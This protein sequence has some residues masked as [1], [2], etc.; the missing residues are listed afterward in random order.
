MRRSFDTLAELREAMDAW[1]QERAGW[2][3]FHLKGRRSD[4]QLHHQLDMLLP[5]VQRSSRRVWRERDG[6]TVTMTLHYRDGVRLADACRTGC[7]H[8]LAEDERKLLAQA[9]E[10][11]RCYS[12]LEAI[13][14]Y[15][16]KRVVYE[17]PKRGF[18]R[19]GE[20]VSCKAVLAEG[21]G[22]C[23][24]ISDAVYLLGTLAGYRM[25][26]QM[27]WNENGVHLWN[28]VAAQEGC[29]ALDVTC[30]VSHPEEKDVLLSKKQCVK[31]GLRWEEWA[32]SCQILAE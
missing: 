23:Q 11:V 7:M 12:T 19:Y 8:S 27:G 24:G 3:S 22:N 4:A 29:Y 2:I 1:Q 16:V 20:I 15:L 30:A 10:I 26:Y 28:T 21:C 18:G 31:R 25:G 17:N 13:Q 5:L 9:E 14:A 32:E 6:H